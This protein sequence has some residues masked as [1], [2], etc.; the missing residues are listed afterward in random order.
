MTAVADFIEVLSGIGSRINE[1]MS[2]KDVENAFLNEH[3]YSTLGY[4]GAGYDLRSEWS[5]PD[6]RR[7]DYVT[8]DE[9]ASVTAVYEFKTAGRALSPHEDQ[10]FH[11]VTELQADYGVLTNGE[12]F[13]LYRQDDRAPIVTV[14]LSGVTTSDATNIQSALRKP[15]WIS[16]TPIA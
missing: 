13:R 11:Y 9:N 14:T 5:L 3:F 7:P 6:Q 10:L 2:E 15:E 12:E 4:E 16:Q 1:E 8:L